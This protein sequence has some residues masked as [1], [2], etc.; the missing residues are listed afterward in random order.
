MRM[1]AGFILAATSMDEITLSEVGSC[2]VRK[3]K[4]V[5]VTMISSR[6]PSFRHRAF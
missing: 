3:E 2:F 6:N 4:T 5:D 1:Y